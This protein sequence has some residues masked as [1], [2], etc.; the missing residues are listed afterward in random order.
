MDKNVFNLFHHIYE[1]NNDISNFA[2]QT[3][4]K[5]QKADLK[6][7][8]GKDI[9]KKYRE[10]FYELQITKM[11]DKDVKEYSAVLQN[12]LMEYHK[13]KMESINLIIR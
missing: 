4:L 8:Q 11:L 2:L 6:V 10:K 1:T 5:K 7:A 12:C 9:E 13:K 3:T